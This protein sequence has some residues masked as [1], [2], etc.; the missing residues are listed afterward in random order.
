[1]K[2]VFCE[3]LEGPDS[4]VVREVDEPGPP[5]KGELK[6][7]VTVRGLA[8]TDVLMSQGK[9]QVQPPLPFVI[10]G[11]GGGTIEEVGPDVNGFSVGDQVLVPAGCIEKVVVSSQAVTRV[12]PDTDLAAAATFRSNYMT[13]IYALQR[14]R[15]EAGEV[16]LVHGAAGGVGLAAV[17]VGKLM[18]ATVIAT[19]SSDE[20]LEVV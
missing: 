1:M 16:L 13:A 11:E 4:L 20:K 10:G 15:L 14:G 7:R 12:P 8:F 17:D 19:A 5:N 18:G 3:R 2:A 6:I 9:Y